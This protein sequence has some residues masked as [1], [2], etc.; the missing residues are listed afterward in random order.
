MTPSTK[1]RGD[2]INFFSKNQLKCQ[3]NP[4]H[5]QIS[6]KVSRF[7]PNKGLCFNLKKKMQWKHVLDL[8]N[9]RHRKPLVK[10]ALNV[11]KV[12]ILTLQ[13]KNAWEE[14]KQLKT[15]YCELTWM[16]TIG[17]HNNNLGGQVTR[18]ATSERFNVM[19]KILKSVPR[20]DRWKI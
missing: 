3:N 8:R 18:G 16:R 7:V 20:V 13:T 12:E 5:K 14:S 2:A 10:I 11:S 4:Q 17:K 9:V 1:V 15:P 19:E 6:D